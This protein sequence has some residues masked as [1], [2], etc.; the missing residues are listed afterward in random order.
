MVMLKDDEV[1]ERRRLVDVCGIFLY[2]F[3]KNDIQEGE[4]M[5]VEKVQ[6]C[7][8]RVENMLEQDEKIS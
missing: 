1:E 2:I 4:M 8:R 6:S 3:P 7:C 5:F